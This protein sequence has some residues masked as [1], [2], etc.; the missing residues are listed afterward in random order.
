MPTRA[1]A[2]EDAPVGSEGVVVSTCM[3][4]GE[5]RL[6]TASPGGC[7]QNVAPQYSREIE[8]HAGSRTCGESGAPWGALAC[9]REIECHAGS[10]TAPKLAFSLPGSLPFSLPLSPRRWNLQ[11]GSEARSHALCKASLRAT[12]SRP[13][14]CTPNAPATSSG[15]ACS[16]RHGSP[17]ALGSR[18]TTLGWGT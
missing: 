4:G 9:T 17:R 16:E 7:R 5:C 6:K 18:C 2:V 14:C 1:R 3:L 15:R 8:C 12:T 10:R 11:M 13:P